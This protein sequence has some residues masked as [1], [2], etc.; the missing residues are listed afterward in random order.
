MIQI[1]PMPNELAIAHEGRIAWVNACNSAADIT[2]MLKNELGIEGIKAPRLNQLSRVCGMSPTD[3]ARQH[4]MLAVRR[5]AAKPGADQLHGSDMSEI[6]TRLQGMLTQRRGAYCCTSCIKEDLQHW[7]FSW[8]RRTHH[9]T[10]VDWCSLHGIPLSVVEDAKPFTQLPH[11]WLDEDKLQRVDTCFDQLPE[12][13]FMKRYVDIS[14]ALLQRA[15]PFNPQAITECLAEQ[16]KKLSLR[17]GHQGQ[18]RRVSDL[19]SEIA[20]ASWLGANMVSWSKKKPLTYFSSVDNV[21]RKKFDPSSG[22]VYAVA[23]AALFN[24]GDDALRELEAYTQR[25]LP[26]T[27]PFA[28]KRRS[29]AFWY[30]DIWPHYLACRGNVLLLAERLQLNRICLKEMLVKIGLPSLHGV[31]NLPKWNAL[32]RYGEGE[33]FDAVCLAEKVDPADLHHLLRQSCARVVIAVKKAIQRPMPKA[34]KSVK[35]KL[36]KPK[37]LVP[38]TVTA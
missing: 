25:E 28:D 10:G 21:A 22:E 3:Y 4:S 8:F 5:V 14:S 33:D 23:L 16:A 2:A 24:S 6:Y 38:A 30:G 36:N 18:G 37:A 32:V 19:L 7:N 35:R 17:V 31:G 29:A 15:Q 26:V 34:V 27:K 1:Q 11:M 9:L 12:S 13:G 20:P